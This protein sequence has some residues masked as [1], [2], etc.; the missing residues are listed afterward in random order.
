MMNRYSLNHYGYVDINN[1]PT[2]Q[3]FA[4]SW[5]KGVGILRFLNFDESEDIHRETIY[6]ALRAKSLCSTHL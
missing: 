6:F 4:G 1:I 5:F 2:P 3:V